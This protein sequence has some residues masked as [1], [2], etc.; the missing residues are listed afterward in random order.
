LICAF[1]TVSASPI[2]A[3]RGGAVGK[4]KQPRRASML[5]TRSAVRTRGKAAGRR[6]WSQSRQLA[7]AARWRVR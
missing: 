2:P 4:A 1:E 7:V 3:R 5:A 6:R